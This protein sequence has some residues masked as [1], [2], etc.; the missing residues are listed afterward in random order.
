LVQIFWQNT[1]TT[2]GNV[3][4]EKAVGGCGRSGWDSGSWVF[5]PSSLLGRIKLLAIFF[6]SFYTNIKTRSGSGSRRA[7][8]T[9]KYRKK[10]CHIL[11]CWMFSFEG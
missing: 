10:N 5:P 2:F 3:V 9:H 8:M 4:E 1:K 11:K 7:K 6:G